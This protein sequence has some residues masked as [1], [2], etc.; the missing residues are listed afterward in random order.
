MTFSRLIWFYQIL[1]YETG[2]RHI[3]M[4]G[5]YKDVSVYNKY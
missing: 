4:A 3:K 5:F 1:S 2:G